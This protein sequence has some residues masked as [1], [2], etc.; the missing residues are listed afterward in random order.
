MGPRLSSRGSHPVNAQQPI[1]SGAWTVPLFRLQRWTTRYPGSGLLGTFIHPID[2]LLYPVSAHGRPS[3]HA[4]VALTFAF[5]AQPKPEPRWC[6][7][8]RHL[9]DESMRCALERIILTCQDE[10]TGSVCLAKIKEQVQSY[11]QKHDTTVGRQRAQT[12][13]Y[14]YSRITD[15]QTALGVHLGPANAPPLHDEVRAS[16]SLQLAIYRRRLR[17]LLATDRGPRVA[18]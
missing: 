17:S 5:S 9:Q 13:R 14:L 4:G 10:S 6:F 15:V 1:Q 16:L 11:V 7:P 3:D 8:P 12:K 2:P 18:R